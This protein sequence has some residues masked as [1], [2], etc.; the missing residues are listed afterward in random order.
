M[1]MTLAIGVRISWD[2]CMGLIK[3]IGKLIGDELD[4]R[5]KE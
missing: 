1:P 3:D 5:I 2:I 4:L